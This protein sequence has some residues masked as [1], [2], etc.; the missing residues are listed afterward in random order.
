VRSIARQLALPAILLALASPAAA[1]PIDLFSA[2]TLT[3]S[4]DVRLTIINGEEGWIDEGLGKLRSGAAGE[5]RAEPQLGNADLVWRPSLG[6]SLSATLVA[7]L[8]GGDGTELGISQAYLSYK[9]LLGGPVRLSA[10]AGLMWPP[11]SL[12]HEGADWNVRDTITPSAINSWI[13]E[14]VRPAAIEISADADL[15]SHEISATG[16]V[17]AAN[18]TAGALLTFRGWALHDR[19]TLAF[20]RQPLPPL[21]GDAQYVQPQYSHPLLDVG[22]GFAKRP[23]FYGRLAWAPPLPV[24]FELFG[25]DNR[26]DPEAVN[27]DLEWGWRTRFGQI[28]AIAELGGATQIKVQALAGRTK[29][30]FVE[31]DGIWFDN[32]F[33]SAFVLVTRPFGRVHAAARLEAFDSRQSG[34]MWDSEYD[35]EGWAATAAARRSFGPHVTGIVE[36]LH[37]SSKRE[38]RHEFGTAPRHGQTQAQASLRFRW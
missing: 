33:R 7:T 15:G 34:S 35:E 16:A 17:F 26:G 36:L 14:E 20:R 13:G 9:P 27:K 8:N 2:E 18:D 11:V 31:E 23:G 37:V 10:R 1:E 21:D 19:K 28:A 24:R 25:Y 6:W 3:M 29:M 5:T 32:R 22:P 38:Q 30:G 12:E 4:G